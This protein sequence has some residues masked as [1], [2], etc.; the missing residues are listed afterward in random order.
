MAAFESVLSDLADIEQAI[1]DAVKAGIGVAH[2]EDQLAEA[3]S[4]CVK[5]Y[6][7]FAAPPVKGA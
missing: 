4:A 1:M 3:T 2:L 7:A 5:A 6:R